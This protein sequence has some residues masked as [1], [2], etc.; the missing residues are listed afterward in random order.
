MQT[1]NTVA[2]RSLFIAILKTTAIYSKRQNS[3]KEALIMY[4]APKLSGLYFRFLERGGWTKIGDWYS[5][6]FGA[7]Q[8][9]ILTQLIEVIV[10]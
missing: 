1:I 7:K 5:E 4:V 2:G 8:L 10:F 9:I 6:M 3:S